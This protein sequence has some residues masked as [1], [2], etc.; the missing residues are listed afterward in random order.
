MNLSVSLVVALSLATSDGGPRRCDRVP[1]DAIP[2]SSYVGL[3]FAGLDACRK[4]VD[5][6]RLAELLDP[7]LAPG[8]DALVREL[9]GELRPFDE[10][11]ADAGIDRAQLRTLLRRPMAVGLGRVTFFGEQAVPSIAVAV[12]IDGIESSA[13]TIVDRLSRVL[14][15]KMRLELSR[16]KHGETFVYELTHPRE[17]GSL[18]AAF[19]D[20]LMLLGNSRRYLEQCLDCWERDRESLTSIAARDRGLNTLDT[21]PLVA[22]TLNLQ[23]IQGLLPIAADEIA[24]AIGVANHDRVFLGAALTRQASR[25]LLYVASKRKPGG[26]AAALLPRK[27][28]TRAARYC[29]PDTLV[30]ASGHIDAERI[31]GATERLF[32]ALPT[33]ARRDLMREFRREF[34]SDFERVPGEAKAL[35]DELA[36]SRGQWTF[37]APTPGQSTLIPHGLVV[38]EAQN[39]ESVARHIAALAPDLRSMTFRDTQIHYAN[40]DAGIRLAPA[41]CVHDGR[42]LISSDIHMLKSALVRADGD[43]QSLADVDDIETSIGNRDVDMLVDVRLRN[44]IQHY[45]PIVQSIA[46]GFAAESEELDLSAVPEVEDMIEAA[47]HMRVG[48]ARHGNGIDLLSEAPIGV[49]TLVAFAGQLIDELL[50]EPK[51]RVD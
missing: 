2:A 16:T 11:L 33:A 43:K 8:R 18:V 3:E 34:G 20:D 44:A 35:L 9:R 46:N 40:L 12:D 42:L 48:A 22:A 50:A 14:R 1:G 25:D 17:N 39:A 45:W 32:A 13:K 6:F 23:A 21:E 26:L 30:F 19:A 31:T 28:R 4:A 37:A 15:Q 24:E 27:V 5:N 41:F 47:P 29:P 38:L 49:G 51:P 36:V 10:A 7:I